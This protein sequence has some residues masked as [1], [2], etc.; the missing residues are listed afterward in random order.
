M[1]FQIFALVR[2]TLHTKVFFSD[3]G[4]LMGDCT[5]ELIM[6]DEDEI[7]NGGGLEN[8]QLLVFAKINPPFSKFSIKSS[9]E[10]D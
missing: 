2:T 7:A 6:E 9:S 3:D 8:L 4:S 1:A 10:F 5:K